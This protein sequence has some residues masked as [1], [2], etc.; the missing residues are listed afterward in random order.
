MHYWREVLNHQWQKGENTASLAAAEQELAIQPECWAAPASLQHRPSVV[1][2]RPLFP[3]VGSRRFTASVLT[4]SCELHVFV[5]TVKWPKVSRLYAK[6]WQFKQLFFA[7]ATLTCGMDVCRTSGS[8][9]FFQWILI[10]GGNARYNNQVLTSLGESR[11]KHTSVKSFSGRME[12]AKCEIKRF[13][14]RFSV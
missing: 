8:F 7:K 10:D 3:C 6:T 13:W 2:N 5:I 12:E 14:I 4:L 1:N 11:R 9:R